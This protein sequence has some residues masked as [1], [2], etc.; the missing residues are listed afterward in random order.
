VIHGVA[1]HL[2]RVVLRLGDDAVRAE[3]V[4]KRPASRVLDDEEGRSSSQHESVEPA[5]RPERETPVLAPKDAEEERRRKQRRDEND[6]LH[7]GRACDPDCCQEGDLP[8]GRRRFEHEREEES[9]DQKDGVERVL[10]HHR[11]RVDERR[12]RHREDRGQQGDPS[13]DDAAREEVGGNGGEGHHERIQRLDR[14]IC[15]REPVED[16]IRRADQRRVDDAAVPGGRNTSHVELARVRDGSSELRVVELV[17]H[18]ERSRHFASEPRPQGK[19]C[20]H[21]CNEPGPRWDP[22]QPSDHAR[23]R[24]AVWRSPSPTA[25]SANIGTSFSG[26]SRR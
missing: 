4:R 6:S 5:I 20:K 26:F 8:N 14:R 17:D 18:D 7:A 13:P 15:V 16:R 22:A 25:V 21:E 2:S 3:E 11:A 1:Q 23:P 9:H 24:R 19:G 10:R 12:Q